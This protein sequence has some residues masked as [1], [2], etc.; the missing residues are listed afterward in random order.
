MAAVSGSVAF[1]EVTNSTGRVFRVGETPRDILGH[2]RWVPIMA[3]WLAMCLAGL[4]EYTWGALNGSLAKVHGWGPGPGTSRGHMPATSATPLPYPAEPR[5]TTRDQAAETY[6]NPLNRAP[7]CRDGSPALPAPDPR[8][9]R[10]SP[11]ASRT[12]GIG[13]DRWP[14]LAEA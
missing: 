10:T 4:L 13:G 14:Q 7:L 6:A 9:R 8:G 1:Q 3:A 2:G 5:I 11:L 12:R